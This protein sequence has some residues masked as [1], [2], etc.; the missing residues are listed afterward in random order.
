MG[1][2]DV[3]AGIKMERELLDCREAIETTTA[4]LKTLLAPQQEEMTV[5]KKSE[6]AE[7]MIK[8]EKLRLQ[9]EEIEKNLATATGKDVVVKRKSD[10]PSVD[11]DF[12]KSSKPPRYRSGQD[13]CVFLDRWVQYVKLSGAEKSPNLDSTLLTLIDDDRTYRKMTTLFSTLTSLQKSSTKEILSA[14]RQRLY[15]NTESRTLRDAMTMMKQ[16]PD[17]SAEDFTVRIEQ[18][19]AKAYGPSDVVLKNEACLSALSNG[20]RS[21]EIRRKLKESD[22]STFESATRLVIKQEHIFNTTI[23]LTAEEQHESLDV[24]KVEQK[25]QQSPQQQYN[26]P[27]QQYN[28]PQQQYNQPQQ[29]YNPPQQQYDNP[30]R[31][32]QDPRR[33]YNHS[34]QQYYPQMFQNQRPP[35]LCYTCNR[36]GHIAKFCRSGQGRQ[37]QNRQN[38]GQ[39][40]ALNT[41]TVGQ[42]VHPHRQ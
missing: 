30:Q 14:I 22:E 16:K 36:P 15:P 2:N 29:Q 4:E 10:Q 33:Q 3:A 17:E 27:Q 6:M 1:D 32:Y 20:L 35:R 24:F 34:Q 37:Q 28:P 9:K 5:A 26:P 41:N 40:G 21:V 42:T 31:Q 12:V 38:N 11:S 8:L 23:D 25:Q 18:E 13:M 39:R 7:V 19:A